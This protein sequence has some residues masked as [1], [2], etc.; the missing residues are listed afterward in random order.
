MKPQKTKEPRK[1][2]EAEPDIAFGLEIDFNE[3]V[4]E[5]SERA[6]VLPFVRPE[7]G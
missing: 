5:F 6:K 7:K 1:R 3:C 4:E 2:K